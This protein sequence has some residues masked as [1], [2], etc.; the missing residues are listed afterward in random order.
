LQELVR[1]QHH[2]L[3]IILLSLA[4]LLARTGVATVQV[5]VVQAVCEAQ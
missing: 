1:Q 2:W 3:L 5:V 4:V